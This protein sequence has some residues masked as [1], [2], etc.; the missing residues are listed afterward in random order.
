MIGRKLESV[1]FSVP[2]WDSKHIKPTCRK[3]PRRQAQIMHCEQWKSSCVKCHSWSLRRLSI[4][5]TNASITNVI[6]MFQLY[7]KN[8]VSLLSLKLLNTNNSLTTRSNFDF[9]VNIYRTLT[10]I[11]YQGKKKSFYLKK[12]CLYG[13]N[14]LLKRHEKQKK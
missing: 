8:Y 7:Q 2:K 9:N 10:W 6:R 1:C 14:T 12:K 13:Y 3:L 11:K 4:R 5:N